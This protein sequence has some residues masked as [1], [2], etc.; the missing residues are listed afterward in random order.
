MPRKNG[1]EETELEAGWVD[2]DDEA[3]DDDK[4]K[5]SFP[6]P[7]HSVRVLECGQPKEMRQSGRDRVGTHARDE[8]MGTWDGW[9]DR[10]AVTQNPCSCNRR[11]HTS[12]Q[13]S[14]ESSN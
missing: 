9:D 14:D 3:E 10:R 8:T 6:L 13:R 1:Q 2:A 12:E 5:K 7:A 11:V 4:L